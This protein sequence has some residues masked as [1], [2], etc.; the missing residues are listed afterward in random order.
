M[1]ENP[2][3][4]M[5]VFAVISFLVKPFS[6]ANGKAAKIRSLSNERSNLNIGGLTYVIT[7]I[8]YPI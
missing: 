7:K 6:W 5:P 2:L 4:L 3:G 1:Q 8:C